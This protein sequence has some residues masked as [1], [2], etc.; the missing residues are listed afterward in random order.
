MRDKLIYEKTMILFF[1][2]VAITAFIVLACKGEDEST[3]CYNQRV[4]VSSHADTVY[5]GCPAV[6]ITPTDRLYVNPSKT[7]HGH[8][9]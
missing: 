7:L 5:I 2:M 9:E 3:D 1:S 4:D 6:L 8:G